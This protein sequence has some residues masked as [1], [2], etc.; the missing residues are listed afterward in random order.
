MALAPLSADP[1]RPAGSAGEIR[2]AAGASRRPLARRLALI[3]ALWG[4]LGTGA[5]GV[6]QAVAQ[7]GG[8]GSG[9]VLCNETSYIVEVAFGRPN[10]AQTIVK[11]WTRFR[12][13]E[14]KSLLAG[15]LQ[16]AVHYLYARASD[17]HRGGVREWGG[18]TDFCVDPRIAFEGAAS[19]EC[20]G[21]DREMR[22][23]RAIAIGR[24]AGWRT[25]LT[26]VDGFTP[27]EARIA[28]IQ[29]LLNDA[30]YETRES[31]GVMGR[32]TTAALARFR[33]DEKLPERITD[34]NLLDALEKSARAW[35]QTV[36]LTLCNRTPG[37]LHAAIG[38]R[39]G[40]TW[41]SRGWW[42]LNSGAC[43]RVLNEPLAQAEY[44]VH[45]VVGNPQGERVLKDDAE[46][47]CVTASRF[48]ISGRTG[49]EERFFEPTGFKVI[50]PGGAEATQVELFDQDFIE[51]RASKAASAASPAVPRPG[52]VPAAPRP[53]S[54]ARPPAPAQ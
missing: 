41:E 42:R 12:P 2:G 28:G 20:S 1:R 54:A 44:F 31:D 26:Q 52:A 14:C 33:L 37:L 5:G 19:K 51:R 32:R 7:Q 47:F 21:G 36:G 13:G 17:A 43:A 49:C 18:A 48:V 9:W 23:F 50:R 40:E 8:A 6:P 11:G 46:I 10:G 39:R 53:T 25:R 45:A 38:R 15:P 34:D 24:K 30:G 4:A 29:R 27:A 3:A 22:S 16:T 35:S